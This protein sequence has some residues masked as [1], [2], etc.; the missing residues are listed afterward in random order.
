VSANSVLHT[1]GS[2]CR[3]WAPQIT[4]SCSHPGW[5][6][7]MPVNIWMKPLPYMNGWN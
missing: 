5:P 7:A 4:L 2:R 1:L 3:K 6:A